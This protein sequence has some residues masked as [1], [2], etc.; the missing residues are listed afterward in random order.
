LEDVSFTM[1]PG[2]LIAVVGPSGAGKTTLSLLLPR[3]YDPTCGC[4]EIDG[5]D[6]RSY[7][8][9]SLAANMAVVSQS[10]YLFYDTIAANIRYARP[11]ASQ[12]E[13]EEACKA[14]NIY[15][16]IKDLPDGFD[17]VVGERGYRLSG[18]ERQRISIARALLKNARILILDEATSSLDSVSERLIQQALE[19]IMQGRTTLVIAH[20]LS[21]ILKAD[22]IIVLDKGHLVEQGTH[23]ELK[24]KNDS[25]YK[26]LYETQFKRDA[27]E[28]STSSN[29]NNSQE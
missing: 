25:L 5:R 19:K 17:T 13:I 14:A 16:V 20:R 8:L 11:S 26:T 4:I 7:T 3:L 6:I 27:E 1:K 10:T 24:S 28:P 21:T 2:E 9:S 18:G 23:Q 29:T 22:R 12:E 15:Q